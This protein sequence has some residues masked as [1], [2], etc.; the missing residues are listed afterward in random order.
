MNAL[1]HIYIYIYKAY[2]NIFIQA[3]FAYIFN[4]STS[5]FY[6]AHLQ[7]IIFKHVA[8]NLHIKRIVWSNISY[9]IPCALYKHTNGKFNKSQLCHICDAWLL[10]SPPLSNYR[11]FLT[12]YILWIEAA[13][14]SMAATDAFDCMT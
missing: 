9:N 12:T 2:E 5:N 10:I 3:K 6:L 8:I 4:Y 13:N 11:I 1:V 14:S 7:N